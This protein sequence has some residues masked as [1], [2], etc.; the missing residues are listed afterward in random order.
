MKKASL[1]E[2]QIIKLLKEAENVIPVPDLCRTYGIARSTFYKW[3]SRYG[4]CDASMIRE[5]KS[6]EEENRRLKRMYAEVQLQNE[7][8]KDVLG[9]K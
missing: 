2:S 4:G 1:N 8:L 6:I 7:L 5:M 9:K 3:R